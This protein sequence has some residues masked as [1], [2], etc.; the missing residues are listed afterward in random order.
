M[1]EYVNNLRVLYEDG[2]ETHKVHKYKKG[3]IWKKNM[4]WWHACIK[5]GWHIWIR[6]WW[7]NW[8]RIKMMILMCM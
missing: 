8:I 3:A 6:M 2:V 5:V 7:H 1:A 4:L